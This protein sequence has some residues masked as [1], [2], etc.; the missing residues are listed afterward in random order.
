[1]KES[2]N[3][4]YIYYLCFKSE[5]AE[6]HGVDLLHVMNEMDS[7]IASSISLAISILGNYSCMLEINKNEKE[8]E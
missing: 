5:L 1:M 2:I 6:K 3:D 7:N 4:K 8:N